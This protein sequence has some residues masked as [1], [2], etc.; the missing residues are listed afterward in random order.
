MEVGGTAA[1]TDE[2]SA[3]LDAE[4]IRVEESD[5]VVEEVEDGVSEGA[6]SVG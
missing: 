2:A 5:D 4:G 3:G 6:L 1:E